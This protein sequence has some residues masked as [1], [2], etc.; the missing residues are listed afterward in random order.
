[1]FI[2]NVRIY[3]QSFFLSFACKLQ[4]SLQLS[5]TKVTSRFLLGRIM[6][7]S[8]FGDKIARYLKFAKL[9]KNLW[10]TLTLGF[11]PRRAFEIRVLN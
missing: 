7:E 8:N 6:A 3:H 4:N 9:I 11:K 2:R 1:M 10:K 5:L